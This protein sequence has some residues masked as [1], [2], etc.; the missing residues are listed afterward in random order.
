M[1][2]LEP[3]PYSMKTNWTDLLPPKLDKPHNEKIDFVINENTANRTI[4]TKLRGVLFQICL[5][6][7]KNLLPSV[8]VCFIMPLIRGVLMILFVNPRLILVSFSHYSSTIW[9]SGILSSYDRGWGVH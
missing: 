4:S 1:E 7:R 9:L 2:P 8:G 3:S 6:R 5:C